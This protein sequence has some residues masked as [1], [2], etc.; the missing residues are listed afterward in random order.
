MLIVNDKFSNSIVLTNGKSQVQQNTS[1][2]QTQNYKNLLHV[3]NFYSVTI[4][5]KYDIYF[6]YS[7]S[8]T[9]YLQQL[10]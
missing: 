5:A 1:C 8:T 6:I 7:V 9:Y 2:S 4:N 3:F 10:N